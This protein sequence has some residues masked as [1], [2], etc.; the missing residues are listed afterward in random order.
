MFQHLLSIFYVNCRH[1]GIVPFAYPN[2]LLFTDLILNRKTQKIWI[3][4]KFRSLKT[5][6]FI[7][8]TRI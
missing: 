1:Y 2:G 4:L 5:F 6:N 7:N 3:I 8:F